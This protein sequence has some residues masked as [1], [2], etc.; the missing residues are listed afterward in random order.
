MEVSLQQLAD[1]R[2]EETAP[3]HGGQVNYN[4]G[5]MAVVSTAK[6]NVV[7]LTSRRVPPFSLRQLTAF[8]IFPRDFEVVVAKGVNAPIAAYGPECPTII[9]VNTPGVTQADMTAFTYKNR[10]KPLF[11][12][13]QLK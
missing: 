2:F 12:F 7:M 8:G 5:D 11:P 13:E 3:R 6:G 10:R 4:M 9:Q 1:G